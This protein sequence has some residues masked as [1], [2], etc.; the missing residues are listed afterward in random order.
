MPSPEPLDRP[1][2]RPPIAEAEG[3]WTRSRRAIK[4]TLDD[5]GLENLTL[6]WR[7]RVVVLAFAV[8]FLA[9]IGYAATQQAA[10][11]K[12]HIREETRADATLLAARFED[13][14][15][16]TDR[17][18]A[19]AAQSIGTNI[20]D[21]ATINTLLQNMRSF[22]PKSVDNIGV[23]ALD[24]AS[25]AALDKRAA[26]RAVK[27]ADRHYFTEA[28]ATR[29]LA[30]EGPIMSRTTGVN[31]VQFAR[32]IF[33]AKNQVVGVISMSMRPS[34]IIGLLDQTGMVSETALVTIVDRDGTIVARSTDQAQ[35]VGKTVPNMDGLKAI[36]ANR[37]GTHEELGVDGHRR[38]A[39]YSVVG[40]WPWAVTVGEPIEKILGAAGDRLL[41]NL[42]IGLV[43]FV[44]AFVIAGRVAAWTSKPLMQLA[45]DTE[46][47]RGGELSHRSGV[48]S[49]G[50]IA[51]LAANFNAMAA[52]I[53]ERDHALTSS[54]HQLHAITDN[55]PA[56]IY[57]VDRDERYRFVNAYRGP[58][59]ELSPADMLG[60]TVR[61]VRGDALYEFLAPHIR[62]GL[63]G[64]ANSV[65]AARIANGRV[66]HF[67]HA[68]V[69]DFDQNGDVRG[70]YCFAQDITERKLADLMRIESEKR[71]VTITDNLPA[72]ICYVD[73]NRRYRFANVAFEK[74]LLRP[75]ADIIGQPF[76]RLMPPDVAA[77]YDYYFLRGMKG[78]ATDY[79]IEVPDANGG[80]RWLKCSFIPDIDETTG[81]ARGVYGMIHNVTKA[82]VAE[83]RLTRLARFDTLTGLANRHQF[84]ETLVQTLVDNQDNPRPMA[85]MFL[86]IDHFKQVNDRHGH[87]CGDLLLKDFAQRLTEN[88]RPTDAVARL[89]GDEFVVLLEG[90]HSDE[91]PQFIARKIIAAVEKPFVLEGHT[92]CVTTSIGIAMHAHADEVPSTFMKRAD[93]ALYDAKRA[94]RNTFRLAS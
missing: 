60:K 29:D 4:Q 21:V 85:L 62:S 11:E 13:H 10:L 30:F 33:D 39:G 8:P 5:A 7:F 72:M 68:Y 47:L 59:P 41:A 58:F 51:L 50:E 20:D 56:Q 66:F 9:F 63:A 90:M 17:L 28:I 92:L 46:R 64:D 14:I 89:S 65:E 94:G 49:G 31:I 23:W 19:T 36:F 18:L 61:E 15:E 45:A 35:W 67:L 74:W 37:T 86:D 48:R 57:Y 70:L 80:S 26:T 55:V 1:D 42:A 34:E 40:K 84:N 6:R 73:E 27:V 78:E 22:V 12:K 24:G 52:E 16:Q 82:K 32:P 75:L 79:E 2:S 87:G 54:R 25:I 69:P 44:L 3:I 81:K 91:E 38:L 93:E 71:L 77:Q 76:D 83:Q 53:E 43:I 88:V